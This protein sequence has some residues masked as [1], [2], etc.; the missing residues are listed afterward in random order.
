MEETQ[1]QDT[2][3]K[4]PSTSDI[5]AAAV[6]ETLSG[7]DLKG[8][9]GEAIQE[10]APPKEERKPELVGD[11]AGKLDGV[12]GDVT[13]PHVFRAI[14]LLSAVSAAREGKMETSYRLMD[15]VR[16][17]MR[18]RSDKQ[19]ADEKR[20]AEQILQAANLPRKQFQRALNTTTATDGPELLPAPLMAELFVILEQ[21][22][23]ARRLFTS[24]NM[25]SKTLD[26]SSV[27]TKPSAAWTDEGALYTVTEPQFVQKTLTLKKLAAITSWNNELDE[28]QQIALLP[29]LIAMLAEAFQEKED[30]AGFVGD[31]TATY[32]SITGILNLAAANVVT[33]E[34][35]SVDFDDLAL[36]H[37]VQTR[38]ALTLKRRMRARWFMHPD[39]LGIAEQLKASDG[40]PLVRQAY[41]DSAP[42]RIYGYPVELTEEMPSSGDTAVST[43]FIAFGDPS[44]MFFGQGRGFSIEQSRDGII[45]NS[46]N[47]VVE[48][49]FQEDRTLLRASERIAINTPTAYESAFAVLRTAAS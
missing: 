41:D 23:N 43:K 44:R 39:I 19:I 27:S 42:T 22:G 36:E 38:D 40:T 45:S 28:D 14:R 37:F 26:L 20:Q 5:V 46:S 1:V 30:A 47:E 3:T 18:E 17:G 21:V 10:Q 12:K 7:M 25:V 32:G 6:R 33:M 15:Q 4:Q 16:T 13:P 24:I 2:E 9:V 8:L 48:N 31:G 35:T 34:A 29:T 49:A 11:A